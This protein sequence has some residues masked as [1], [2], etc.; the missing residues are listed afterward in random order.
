[1]KD[2]ASGRNIDVQEL[3]L[4]A[5][6]G[7]ESDAN[8]RLHMGTWFQDNNEVDPGP[9]PPFRSCGT[10][11]CLVGTYASNK[12]DDWSK[13]FW[14]RAHRADDSELAVILKL[15]FG[16]SRAETRFLF[17]SSHVGFCEDYGEGK[18]A[19]HACRLDGDDAVRRLRKFLYYKMRKAEL[20]EDY[21]AARNMEGNQQFVADAVVHAEDCVGV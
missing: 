17:S 21:E 2:F 18:H 10:D 16:L 9:L 19:D 7:E 13:M 4:M 12:Q 5:G 6:W 20:L 14:E 8:G 3:L 1:M 11:G 15:K